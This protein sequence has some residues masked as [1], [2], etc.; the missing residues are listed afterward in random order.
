MAIGLRDTVGGGPNSPEI[1]LEFDAAET[2]PTGVERRLG[3]WL[4][5]A[6]G[7]RP[8]F[9]SMDD[10]SRIIVD[11]VARAGFSIDPQ[12]LECSF[13]KDAWDGPFGAFKQ[14]A[15]GNRLAFTNGVDHRKRYSVLAPRTY[16]AGIGSGQAV[17]SARITAYVEFKGNLYCTI[18]GDLIYRL[19]NWSGSGEGTAYWTEVF[20]HSDNAMVFRDLVVYDNVIYAAGG[21]TA[22]YAY[23]TDG[24][25]WTESNR[26]GTLDKAEQWRVVNN[27]LHK[28]RVPNLHYQTQDGRNGAGSSND[29]SSVDE[30]GEAGDTGTMTAFEIVALENQVT[31]AKEEG[32]FQLPPEGEALDIYP[33]LQTKRDIGNGF[34]AFVWNN[35]LQYPTYRGELFAL[36]GGIVN[37]VTPAQSVERR[38]GITPK[39]R[40]VWIGQVK[41]MASTPQYLF[42]EVRHPG[43][44]FHR[45]LVAEEIGGRYIW[46][47]LFDLETAT[48]DELFVS[49]AA[50]SGPV[51]WASGDTEL[52]YMAS[53]WV[54]AVGPD[55]TQDTRSRYRSGGI[56]YEPWLDYGIPTTRKRWSFMEVEATAT[57][58]TA[59]EITVRAIAE[60]GRTYQR[61]LTPTIK[62]VR[63]TFRFPKKFISERL[64]IEWDYRTSDANETPTIISLMIKGI[65]LP[66]PV[67][68]FDLTVDVPSAGLQTGLATQ[69]KARA[70]LLHVRKALIPMTLYDVRYPGE[71]P[72]GAAN[73]VPKTAWKVVSFPPSPTEV[74]TAHDSQKWEESWRLTFIEEHTREDEFNDDDE[75]DDDDDGDGDGD[76]GD[77]PELPPAECFPGIGGGPEHV[78]TSGITSAGVP[79]IAQTWNFMSDDADVLW[80]AIGIEGIT[81]SSDV[82]ECVLVID[83][84]VPMGKQATPTGRAYLLVNRSTGTNQGTLYYSDLVSNVGLGPTTTWTAVLTFAIA[85]A[86]MT[87]VLDDSLFTILGVQASIAEGDAAART[88]Y[89]GIIFN[90]GANANSVFM[91]SHNKGATWFGFA[92]DDSFDQGDTGRGDFD[93]NQRDVSIVHWG[94]ETATNKFSLRHSHNHGHSFLGAHATTD[95]SGGGLRTPSPITNYDP[96]TGWVYF[97]E[98]THSGTIRKSVDG[99]HNFFAQGSANVPINGYHMRSHDIISNW[100]RAAAYWREGNDFKRSIDD[101]VTISTESAPLNTIASMD[102]YMANLVRA[103]VYQIGINS[104]TRS[105]IEAYFSADWIV[106]VEHTGDLNSIAGGP[107]AGGALHSC[108]SDFTSG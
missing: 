34:H 55:P 32:I 75:D 93:L 11:Q 106:F 64:R 8:L 20:D 80:E 9:S 15:G 104:T 1:D 96:D 69:A 26:G 71:P 13:I 61:I 85:D 92:I 35:A 14:T 21:E 29:W 10:A 6:Q 3:F 65:A 42:A 83:P 27:W 36:K 103:N 46:R 78:V 41:A 38:L 31:F 73:F 58:D 53:Y 25:S 5:R 44:T 98:D 72:P 100:D 99:G 66:P 47:T 76:G 22:A 17:L 48:S 68:V 81:H 102:G 101:F 94:A 28:I 57:H 4:A 107:G 63:R 7:Q 90:S 23:S 45:I 70:F 91:H 82:T 97:N 30:I 74:V 79:W 16:T 95:G 88:G 59:C 77:C 37:M 39:S 56:A 2:L 62:G 51:L 12:T 105:R 18:E 19:D 50:T 67:R 89:I 43:G 60:S 86:V 84:W 52:G 108:T 33:E 49:S 24:S 40:E 87:E 54:L